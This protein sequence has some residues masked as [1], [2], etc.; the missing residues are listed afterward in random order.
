MCINI[1]FCSVFYRPLQSHLR[2]DYYVIDRQSAFCSLCFSRQRFDEGTITNSVCC[3]SLWN[4]ERRFAQKCWHLSGSACCFRT[5]REKRCT[6]F[7]ELN[8]LPKLIC[9]YMF[10]YIMALSCNVVV[11]CTKMQSVMPNWLINRGML[12]VFL[13]SAQVNKLT[14]WW[15]L[16]PWKE[17]DD[18][19]CTFVTGRNKN[20]FSLSRTCHYGCG[21]RR[22]VG[23]YGKKRSNTPPPPPFTKPV[24]VVISWVLS[25]LFYWLFLPRRKQAVI[26]LKPL[27]QT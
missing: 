27:L 11:T 3:S 12:N 10:N 19:Q 4:K 21:S 5:D 2:C 15:Q 16:W 7:F 1:F 8:M 9:D 17:R 24:K 6:Y 26:P 13:K 20:Y 22:G 23:P 14:P 18:L 25:E